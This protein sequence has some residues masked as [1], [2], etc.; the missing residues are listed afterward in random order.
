[1]AEILFHRQ[2]VEQAFSKLAVK[3]NH[4]LC[5]PKSWIL[6]LLVGKSLD[7]MPTKEVL[8]LPKTRK[9]SKSPRKQARAKAVKAN[10]QSP[11]KRTVN[12]KSY[13][14]P[15]D[16]WVWMWNLQTKAQ[17]WYF[18]LFSFNVLHYK[19]KALMYHCQ[20]R[21]HFILLICYSI[22]IFESTYIYIYLKI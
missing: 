3:A 8:Y 17:S 11:A 19:A 6:S 21:L 22:T 16:H 5:E 1:M 20:I 14:Y 2:N 10:L 12:K 4:E 9:W 13:N 15:P 18:N 7:P